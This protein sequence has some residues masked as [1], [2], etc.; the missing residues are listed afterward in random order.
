MGNIWW[1]CW[2]NEILKL[3]KNIYEDYRN[4]VLDLDEYKQLKDE[5]NKE[6]EELIKQT[7]KLKQQRNSQKQELDSFN[8]WEDFSKRYI[9]VEELNSQ[10][11]NELVDT[12]EIYE[13]KS[14]EV[15]LNIHYKFKQPYIDFVMDEQ[16]QDNITMGRYTVDT[17]IKDL[18][19]NAHSNIAKD[20]KVLYY[21]RRRGVI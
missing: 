18:Y 6:E 19:N 20:L 3:K 5:Y 7:E 1:I 16:Y 2:I 12:I 10:M 21:N 13:D 14:E 4:N 8:K 9:D 17:Y 15:T 11:L